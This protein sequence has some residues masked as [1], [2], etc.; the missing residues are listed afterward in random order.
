MLIV[1]NFFATPCV[2]PSGATSRQLPFGINASSA[3]VAPAAPVP[4]IQYLRRK[5]EGR[6]DK[7][8]HP[9]L[10][11]T[12][13]KRRQALQ[14]CCQWRSHSYSTPLLSS[15]PLHSNPLLLLRGLLS[16]PLLLLLRPGQ[17]L[18]MLGLV[19]LPEPLPARIEL[20]PLADADRAG[21]PQEPLLVPRLVRMPELR[22]QRLQVRIG[23]RPPQQRFHLDAV[24][25]LKSAWPIP[26][27]RRLRCCSGG[28]PRRGCRQRERRRRW[29]SGGRT[30]GKAGGFGG[31]GEA[32]SRRGLGDALPGLRWRLRRGPRQRRWNPARLLP[33]GFRSRRFP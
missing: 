33:R 31:G 3:A 10:Q 17:L 30:G 1:L 5:E 27:L 9:A 29:G 23:P 13:G 6:R 14:S 22:V 7:S 24:L 26:T 18:I 2:A 12:A 21:H 32:P 11:T 8:L 16:T 28:H 25:V 19:V 20:A 15:T 4:P